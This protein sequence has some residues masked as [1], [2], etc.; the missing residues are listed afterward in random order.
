[1]LFLTLPFFAAAQEN[2]FPTDSPE[3]PTDENRG[4]DIA[5]GASGEDGGAFTLSKGG[6]AAIIV[7]VV[8]IAVFGIASLVLWYVAKKRQWEVRKSIRRASRRLT[9]RFE[10]SK[11]RRQS[12]AGGVRV[13]TPPASKRANREID[14]EKG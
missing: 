7:V 3:T 14:L 11:S 12:R 6:L 2:T 10:A 1:L 13:G 4:P 9:G 8:V 5:A